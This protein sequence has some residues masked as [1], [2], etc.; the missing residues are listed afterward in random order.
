M[1][2]ISGYTSWWDS[3]RTHDGRTVRVHT[4]V[5]ISG[6]TRLWDSQRTQDGRTLSEHTEVGLTV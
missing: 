4:M 5:T 1:V 3:Q 6:Y 2:T